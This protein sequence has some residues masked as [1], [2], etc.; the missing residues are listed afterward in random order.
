M[1][2]C[3]KSGFFYVADHGVDDGLV[4]RVFEQCRLFFSLPEV[5]F[6]RRLLVQRETYAEQA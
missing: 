1:Q 3:I 5:R 4:Q 2:A 6:P